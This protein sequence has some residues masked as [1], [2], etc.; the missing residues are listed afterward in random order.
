MGSEFTELE[1]PGHSLWVVSLHQ[2]KSSSPGGFRKMPGD[3]SIWEGGPLCAGPPAKEAPWGETE[4]CLLQL[5]GS[6]GEIWPRKQQK[7]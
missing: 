7:R 1:W 5:N 3:R 2:N 6:D 4:A